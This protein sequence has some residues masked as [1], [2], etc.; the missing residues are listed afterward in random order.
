MH[1]IPDCL[2]FFKYFKIS[3]GFGNK[4]YSHLITEEWVRNF[5]KIVVQNLEKYF[6]WKQNITFV[7]AE[8]GKNVSKFHFILHCSFF[9]PKESDSRQLCLLGS[10]GS[11]TFKEIHKILFPSLKSVIVYKT[12]FQAM[13]KIVRNCLKQ[14]I[15][16]RL[17]SLNV[18]L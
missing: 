8:T 1:K 4:K 9:Y 12:H 11:L 13:Y 5:Y 2:N 7:F 14:R 16:A 10:N 18:H 15:I 17:S 6:N 3:F